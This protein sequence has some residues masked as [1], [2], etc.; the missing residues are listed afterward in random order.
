MTR[1]KTV[2][3]ASFLERL[4]EFRVLCLTQCQDAKLKLVGKIILVHKQFG[5]FLANS[6]RI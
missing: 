3:L 5:P 4:P 2:R 1:Q 6:L